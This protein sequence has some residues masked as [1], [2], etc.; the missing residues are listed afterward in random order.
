[1]PRYRL[2]SKAFFAPTLLPEG[3]VIEYSGTPGPHMEPLDDDAQAA[4]DAYYKAHPE[5]SLNPVEALPATVEQPLVISMADPS[6]VAAVDVS[7][8][9]AAPGPALPGLTD[10]GVALDPKSK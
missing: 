9:L 10:G 1:M 8:G 3:T 6:V 2:A 5:A 7:T 4:M